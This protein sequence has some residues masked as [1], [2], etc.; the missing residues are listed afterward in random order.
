MEVLRFR[1]L[2]LEGGGGAEMM[3]AIRFF[4]LVKR[5]AYCS[6]LSDPRDAAI[7]GCEAFGVG[8]RFLLS[9]PEELDSKEAERTGEESGGESVSVDLASS[10]G[11][12]S[13]FLLL[14]IVA[15]RDRPGFKWATILEP[16]EDVEADNDARP[17]VECCTAVAVVDTEFVEGRS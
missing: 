10:G 15:L 6:K 12:G 9:V 2:S 1:E 13:D 5:S 3:G 14:A 8:D 11:G 17:E 16:R 7:T 4:G